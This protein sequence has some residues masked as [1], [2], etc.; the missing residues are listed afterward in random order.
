MSA[1]GRSPMDSRIRVSATLIILGLLVEGVTMFWNTPGAFLAFTFFGVGLVFAG[2][3]WFL[4]SYV[5]KRG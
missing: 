4:V 3:A 2:F 1:A 5:T